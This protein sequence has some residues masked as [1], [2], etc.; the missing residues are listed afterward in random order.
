MLR[1]RHWASSNIVVDRLRAFGQPLFAG[2]RTRVADV[3]AMVRAGEDF[4][5]IADELGI[6]LDGLRTA[7]RILVGHAA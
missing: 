5:V 1:L 4:E 3:A 2:S 6:A 7:A